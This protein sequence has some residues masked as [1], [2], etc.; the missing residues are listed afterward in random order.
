MKSKLQLAKTTSNN[1][2]DNSSLVV[3]NHCTYYPSTRFNQDA[4]FTLIVK[5]QKSIKHSKSK[6]NLLRMANG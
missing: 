1:S 3:Y 5:N 2:K 4:S 6:K